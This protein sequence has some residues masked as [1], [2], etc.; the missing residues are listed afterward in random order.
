MQKC[1]PPLFFN[2]VI[3]KNSTMVV[4][5]TSEDSKIVQNQKL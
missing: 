3:L 1:A 5:R 4:S 2:R